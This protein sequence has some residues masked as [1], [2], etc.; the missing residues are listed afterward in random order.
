MPRLFAVILMFFAT[1]QGVAAAEKMDLDTL[2]A[3]PNMI[4]TTPKNP[5]WSPDHQ[6]IAF[7]WNE[8]GY[9]FRDV[10]VYDSATGQKQRVT[11]LDPNHQAAELD[12]GVREAVWLSANTL[13]YSLKGEM[14]VTRLNGQAKKVDTTAQGV[15]NLSLSPDG[16]MLAYVA[17]G[18]LWVRSSDLGDEK[19]LTHFG[20]PKKAVSDFQWAVMSDKLAFQMIDESP[21]VVRDVHF[22][23]GD[24]E[25][26]DHVSRAY[27][28][29]PTANYEVGVA[30][31][32]TG[33]V[34][35]M[36]RPNKS[37]LLWGYGLSSDGKRL[38]INSSEME[39]KHHTIYMYDVATA[40]RSVYYYEHD[41]EHTRPDWK[42]HW[43]PKDDGLIILTDKDGYLH[44]YHQ[45]VAQGPLT[46]ITKGTWEIFSFEVDAAH[47]QAYF[48]AN[49]ASLPEQQLYRLSLNGGDVVRVSNAT[50]GTH[51]VT[52][53]ADFSR[54]ASIFSNDDTPIELYD[55]DLGSLKTSAVTKSPLK[56]FYQ[57]PWNPVIYEHFDSKRDGL[58]LIAR[59]TRPRDFQEGKR[60]PLIIGSVYSD[61]VRNQYGG[62][63]YH[64]TGRLDQYFASQ[65]YIVMNVNIRGS[66]GQ[67][68]A[69]T[70]SQLHGY[71]IKDIDDLQSGALHLVEKGWVD[72]KRIGIW[73]SSYG[74][75]MTLNSL[76]KKPGFYAAGVAGAPASNV[77]HAYPE[78]MWIMG[79]YD[80]PDQPERYNL[81]SAKFHTDGLADPLMIIH[82]TR[83]NVV[84]YADTLDFVE[85]LMKAEKDF[86]LVTL[87]GVVHGWDAG[88]A[89]VRRFAFKKMVK[90]FNQH[91][92]K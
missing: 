37:D 52:F 23:M 50:P 61:S 71:G 7:V 92:M 54:A 88:R 64:P 13:A 85:R 15:R 69:H 21:V 8:G 73:G 74:G 46:P 32:I 10:W 91:L 47:N 9:N 24:K 30:N 2:Y 83:D 84:M 38:F 75:L 6:K 72:E 70:N 31:I 27:P 62:R 33:S 82:G 42:V 58:P 18:E 53:N 77:R 40:K 87:P 51:E 34:T 28:G 48:I 68:R 65:G 86:E 59:I 16:K 12:P 35:M 39:I 66:W 78:Q 41:P 90:F 60:Y 20:H 55:I 4:G 11:N 80:G 25:H 76:F 49:K 14:F 57:Q 44:L 79:P 56:S 19:P 89:D 45:R 26:V 43:A 29:E 63:I 3:W 81:Q 5:A 1:M 67:G 22:E 36:E 17:G